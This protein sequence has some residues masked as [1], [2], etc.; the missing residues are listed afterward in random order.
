MTYP[1]APAH[2][3]GG[4][5]Y[6]CLKRQRASAPTFACGPSPSTS[7]RASRDRRARESVS[8]AP[9]FDGSRPLSDPP[10]HRA[11]AC[12]RTDRFIFADFPA[13]LIFHARPVEFF[14]MEGRSASQ[15]LVQQHSQRIDVTPCSDVQPAHLRLLGAHASWRADE[16]IKSVKLA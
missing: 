3:R 10:H 6:G 5:R 14:G 15:Q 1:Q 11:Q 4:S 9:F 16:L 2:L 12:G 8:A 13:H 7:S